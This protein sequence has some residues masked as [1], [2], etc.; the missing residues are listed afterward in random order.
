[1]PEINI[2]GDIKG[3]KAKDLK[4]RCPL[5]VFDV[6]G[7]KAVVTNE[8][9]CTMCR[10]CI[11]EDEEFNSKIELAKKKEHF[12]FTVESVGIYEPHEIVKEAI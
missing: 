9:A 10:E 8:R 5:K 11:R 12:I 1:M 3:E 4:A 7:D 6:E 2:N